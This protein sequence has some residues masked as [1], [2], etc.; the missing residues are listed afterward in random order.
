MTKQVKFVEFIVSG[1]AA[2]T[3]ETRIVVSADQLV[4][5][6]MLAYLEDRY[7]HINFREAAR[8]LRPC[9]C[10]SGEPWTTC[11]AQSPYCG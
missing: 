2:L 3:K 4:N 7:P 11:G 8:N 6:E 10:G 9:N 1:E 5:A